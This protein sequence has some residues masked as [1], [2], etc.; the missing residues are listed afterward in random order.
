MKSE[1]ELY[2]RL[3]EAY[4]DQ[5]L[6][7]ITAN[8]IQIYKSRHYD[9]IRE[10]SG[11]I[12]EFIPIDTEKINKCFSKLVMLYH[13]DKGPNYRNEIEKNFQIGDLR[14]QNQLSHI[15]LIE[16]INDLSDDAMVPDDIDYVPEYGWE[17]NLDGF[18]YFTDQDVE[19]MDDYHFPNSEKKQRKVSFI[20]AFKRKVFGNADIEF[21]WN[22]LGNMEELE[23]ADY[24]I[25]DLEGVESCRNIKRLDLSGNHIT[26]LSRLW[27]LTKLEELFLAENKILNIDALKNL[28]N[29]KVIDLSNNLINDISPLFYLIQP[30]FINLSGNKISQNMLKKLRKEGCIILSD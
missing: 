12:S 11:S 30:E 6:N 15:F 24:E 10:I 16:F 3:L 8:L 18:T 22:Q 14:K 9:L 1:K 28:R 17:E 7:Q 27:T 29:L 2:H 25:T 19:V 21:F 20:N 26:E 23:I 5:N 13:P 4:S